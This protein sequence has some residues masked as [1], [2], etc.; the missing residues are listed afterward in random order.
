MMMVKGEKGE[1]DLPIFDPFVPV[2]PLVQQG[3][4]LLVCHVDRIIQR[5]AH[6]PIT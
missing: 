3:D 2:P 1:M 5:Q 4:S 6:L